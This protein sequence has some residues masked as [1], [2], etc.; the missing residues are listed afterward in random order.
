MKSCSWKFLERYYNRKI[1]LCLKAAKS[2]KQGHSDLN[3]QNLFHSTID[4]HPG[5]T[6]VSKNPD[7]QTEVH[8]GELECQDSAKIEE[9]V[10]NRQ[11]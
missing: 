2:L 10:K 4:A 9:T 8:S 1:C 7:Y 5:V 11:N 6:G 3:D